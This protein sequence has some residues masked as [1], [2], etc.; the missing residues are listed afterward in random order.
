MN[1]VYQNMRSRVGPRVWHV[2]WPILWAFGTLIWT[3]I[4]TRTLPDLAPFWTKIGSFLDPILAI[5]PCIYV[6]YDMRSRVGPRLWP[7]WTHIR[8]FLDPY[9]DP[10]LYLFRASLGLIWTKTGSHFGTLFWTRT[11]ST[12][13]A[14]KYYQSY[15][16]RHEVTYDASVNC[17]NSISTY[18]HCSNR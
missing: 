16:L 17:H 2:L 6:L 11:D 15:Y 10:F 5:T 18:W 4:W 8:T 3:L 13:Y 9:L 14:I 12:L 1:I 7:I